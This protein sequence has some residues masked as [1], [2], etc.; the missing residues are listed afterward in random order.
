[1]YEISLLLESKDVPA[2]DGATFDRLN[3]FTGNVATRAAAAQIADASARG[4]RR[5]RAFPAWSTTGPERPA[6][7]AAQGG[8]PAGSKAPQFID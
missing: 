3:P 2:S 5:S 6:R 1:M 8:G 4:R 7:H